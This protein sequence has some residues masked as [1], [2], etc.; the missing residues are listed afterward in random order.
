MTNPFF[1]YDAPPF[2]T[3]PTCVDQLIVH[4][5]SISL[6]TFIIDNGGLGKK[7]GWQTDDELDIGLFTITINAATTC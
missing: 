2:T 5:N 3:D 1:E 7:V 6:N 4:S